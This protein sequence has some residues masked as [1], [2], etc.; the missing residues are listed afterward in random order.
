MVQIR[1][2]G[3]PMPKKL[4]LAVTW[5]VPLSDVPSRA[6]EA[7]FRQPEVFTHVCH[8]NRVRID[9]ARLL[10]ESDEEHLA[11]WVTYLDRWIASA[12]ARAAEALA[13]EAGAV[14]AWAGLDGDVEPEPLERATPR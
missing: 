13:I 5:V 1:R 9:G 11:A 2:V 12:N 7:F 4:R 14:E 6:W 8:P 10:F 3:M